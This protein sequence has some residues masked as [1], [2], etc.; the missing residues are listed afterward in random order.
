MGGF[1]KVLR[2]EGDSDLVRSGAEVV[3]VVVSEVE[4]SG[5]SLTFVDLD[6]D[7]FNLD[8]F[9]FGFDFCFFVDPESS[10]SPPLSSRHARV[11]RMYAKGTPSLPD[12]DRNNLQY[13]LLCRATSLCR[14][15]DDIE[16][17][18]GGKEEVCEDAGTDDDVRR[19]RKRKII[20]LRHF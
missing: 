2:T 7:L 10:T 11:G 8:L 9:G 13:D 16:E 3:V 12:N 1:R 15:V 6:L 4:G 14:L 20:T 19:T 17:G 18:K 5:D